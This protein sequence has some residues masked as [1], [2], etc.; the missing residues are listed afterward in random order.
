MHRSRC[1]LLGLA[2][3]SLGAAG[4]ALGPSADPFAGGLSPAQRDRPA[5]RIQ[6]EVVCDQ[7]LISYD[8]G[9]RNGSARA[10]EANQ[11]WSLRLV[12]YPISSQTVRLTA[13]SQVTAVERVRIFV[14]GEL[15]AS[16][17]NDG[18]RATLC[19]ATVIPRRAD[20]PTSTEI[21]CAPNEQRGATPEEQSDAVRR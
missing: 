2:V 18:S 12:E 11:V 8:V 17:A 4:C 10:S 19:A 20:A 5:V 9:T 6:L 1:P 14:D 15:A 16:D 13:T 3:L 7:C 21:G